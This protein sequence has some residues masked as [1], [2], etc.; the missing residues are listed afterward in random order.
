MLKAINRVIDKLFPLNEIPDALR[1]IRE[2]HTKG[3]VI[4]TLT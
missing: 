2:V 1:Y 4:I 3:K